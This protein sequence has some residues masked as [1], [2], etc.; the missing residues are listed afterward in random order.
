MPVR[1]FYV[2]ANLQNDEKIITGYV[3][4]KFL[5]LNGEPVVDPVPGGSQKTNIYADGS[6]KYKTSGAIANPNNYLIV[7]AN[8]TEQQARAF[9]A[10]IA[11][12]MD[13][14]PIGQA[15][16]LNRMKDAF[17]SN[18]SQ[19]LQRHPQWGIP[20]N[21]FVRAF[22]DSASYH[23]GSVTRWAG[24]PETL[25]DVGGGIPH[26]LSR[27]PDESDFRGLSQRNYKNI[28]KGF[29]DADVPRTISSLAKNYGYNP[30]SEYPAGQIGDGNGLGVGDWRFSLAGVDPMTPTQP[31]PPPQTDSKPAPRLV[32]VNS[33]T[34]PVSVSV[35]GVPARVVIQSNNRDEFSDRFGTWGYS[36]AGIAPSPPTDPPASF[37]RRFGNWA[38]VPADGSVSPRSPVLRALEKYKR[39]P[40]PDGA[41]PT[42]GSTR[43]NANQPPPQ[44]APLPGILSGQPMAS[45]LPPSALSLPGNSG[46]FGR[47]DWFDFLA[48]IPAQEQ[49]PPASAPQPTGSKPVRMLGRNIVGQL[50]PPVIDTGAPAP[51]LAPSAETGFSGGLL[52]R[53]IV[54]A[55]IDPQNPTQPASS[56]LGDQ[57]RGFYRDDPLQPWLVRQQR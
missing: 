23:L 36:T 47:G 42:S 24:L 2:G 43:P 55:G 52:G 1:V 28:S 15:L 54:L 25:S 6:D 50:S 9:A 41:M 37:D 40:V 27:P 49:A 8:Y 11:G 12:T 38:S 16:A 30:Q 44:P 48:R 34:S 19:D 46:A 51:P 45:R 7:P 10:H 31:T 29:S 33:K 26:W 18:G 4:A 13:L 5:T 22:I 3:P 56:P 17:W 32:R 20:E 57:L 14:G 35:P 39:S 21:S 53:L